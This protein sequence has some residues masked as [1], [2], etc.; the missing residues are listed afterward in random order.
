MLVST[1]V[2]LK[3]HEKSLKFRQRWLK[4]NVVNKVVNFSHVRTAFFS[5]AISPFCFIQYHPGEVDSS[6]FVQ[7]WS[8][9]KTE[10]IDQVQAVILSL[11]DLHRVRQSDLQNNDWLWKTYWWGSHHDANLIKV[12]KFEQPLD[13]LAQERS[14]ITGQGYKL[15]TDRSY[16]L[17]TKHKELPIDYFKRYGEIEKSQLTSPPKH[18]HR[19]GIHDVFEGWRLLVKRGITQAEGTDGRIEVRLEDKSYCFRNSVH[20]I[21]VDNATDWERKVRHGSKL[22]FSTFTI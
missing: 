3:R 15:G 19:K 17:D 16:Q 10:Y 2:L 9:K 14:W 13:I 18:V 5:G 20:G 21:R 7:Y 22:K 6:H 12:L 4:E 8:A 11:P 1:G